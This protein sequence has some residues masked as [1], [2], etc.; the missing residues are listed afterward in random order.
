LLLVAAPW[1]V[2]WHRNFF[3]AIFPWLDALMATTV[4]RAWVMTTGA[5]TAIAGMVEVYALVTGR[6]GR[7]AGPHR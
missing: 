3:A 2:W 6:R 7:Q 4:C 5:V 1:T